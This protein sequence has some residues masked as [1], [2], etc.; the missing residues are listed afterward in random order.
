MRYLC[1]SDKARRI[2]SRLIVRSLLAK[3]PVIFGRLEQPDLVYLR[4]PRACLLQMAYNAVSQ[5]EQDALSDSGSSGSASPDFHHKISSRPRSLIRD[6][7]SR[8]ARMSDASRGSYTPLQHPTPDLQALQGAY[9]S[10]IERLELSAERLSQSGSDIGEELRKLK[11][12]QKK[13]ESRRSSLYNR[14]DQDDEIHSPPSRQFSYGYGSHASNSIVGTNSV[15]RSGG[16][17]PAAYVASPRGSI[18]SGSWSHHSSLRARSGSQGLRIKQLANIKDE[19]H[20]TES[21]LSPVLG[22]L[23]PIVPPTQLANNV[24]RI[25]NNEASDVDAVE[26]SPPILQPENQENV[27]APQRHAST[28]T[29]QRANELFENFDGVHIRPQSPEQSPDHDLVETIPD[30]VPVQKR[31]SH[32]SSGRPISYMEPQPGENMVYYPAPVPMMLNLPQKLS[33]LPPTPYRDKRKSQMLSELEPA[34]RKAA[35]WL[36]HPL[37]EEE[38]SPVPDLEPPSPRKDK[39]RSVADLP[40]QL[41]ASVYFDYPSVP[42]DIQLK[43]DS[44]VA[45]LDSILDASAH[46]PVSAFT[47]HPIAG[48]VGPEVYGRPMARNRTSTLP[49][50]FTENR[51]RRSS[52][53]MLR[54]NSSSN[55][56]EDSKPR[57]NSMLSLGNFG[58]RKSSMPLDENEVQ[59]AAY[60]SEETP[61]QISEDTVHLGGV[62]GEEDEFHDAQES[63]A[64]ED[65]DQRVPGDDGDFTGAPTTLLAELQLRKQQQKLRNRQAATAYPNGMHSTLLEMDAVA[66]VEKR[67]REKR[68]IQLAWED[69]NAQQPGAEND[70]DEDIPL[71]MLYPTQKIKRFGRAEQEAPLGLIARRAMEDHESLAQRR[72]RLRGV[73]IHNQSTDRSADI[74]SHALPTS[75]ALN[76]M[77]PPTESDEI[78]GETLAHRLKRLK[79]KRATKIPASRPV[80]G[81]FASE[82]LSQLGGLPNEDE[83]KNSPPAGPPTNILPPSTIT[84]NNLTDDPPEET[85]GQRRLR[86]QAQ[87]HASNGTAPST[88]A[89]PATA[90][91]R[92]SPPHK[93]HSMASILSAHPAAGAGSRNLSYNTPTAPQAPISQRQTSWTRKVSAGAM[94]MAAGIGVPNPM[95]VA[96]TGGGGKEEV[97]VGAM[98][99]GKGDM[100]DRWRQSVGF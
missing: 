87:R 20:S 14:R 64:P 48:H 33:K 32:L 17:S 75:A 88:A 46:A 78:E 30:E 58:R 35:P 100:I 19:H 72:A 60:H 41:R 98:D 15:A 67:S 44:A 50:E 80:S 9:I 55:L 51:K 97:A 86:L 70:D 49:L 82:M 63:L 54:R 95:G 74:Y 5:G 31:F 84:D 81:D 27:D 22:S 59:A 76:N 38:E 39:R 25:T 62:E 85:L 93:R 99:R 91:H 89:A 34:A 94:P 18:R 90:E 28:D 69:P 11:L 43:G 13:S 53:N 83:K 3:L 65:E 26:Q 42:Q 73:P 77:E 16:F 40:P 21:T 8:S 61:L 7:F 45:T 36:P 47:D 10:N 2:A 6:T 66:Q 92:P 52:L 12:E 68:H 29:F 79:T 1:T 24:L 56:L 4:D 23:M 96:V 57:N 37:G 71:G